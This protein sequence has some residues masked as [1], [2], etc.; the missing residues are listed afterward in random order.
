MKIFLD[1]I[2]KTVEAYTNNMV[3]KSKA[4]AMHE[5]D[6]RS[7]FDIL[8]RYKLKLN[9]SKCSF[10]VSSGKFLG[11]IVT[12]RGI[13]A[14][15]NQ[16]QAIQKVERP[17]SRKEVQRL[18]GMLATLNPFLSRSSDKCQPM[19]LAI[20]KKAERVWDEQC[21]KALSQIK[22]YLSSPPVLSI[23]NPGEELILYLAVSE[24]A[25]S[26]ALMRD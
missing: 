26:A 5:E 11:Y 22:Q 19:F 14:N 16:I 13:E 7:V 23:P 12:Q 17:S 6:L 21:D 18:T 25:V 1:E 20:K 9:G 4:Q 3:V 10:G 24:Y 8:W 2:G 15:L